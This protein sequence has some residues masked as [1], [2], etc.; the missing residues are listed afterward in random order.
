MAYINTVWITDIHCKD[1]A[2]RQDIAEILVLADLNIEGI[3]QVKGVSPSDI[4]V[5]GSGYLTSSALITY[6]RFYMYVELL[7]AYWG[8]AHGLNDIYYEKLQYFRDELAKAENG[9]TTDNI[10]GNDPLSQSSFI[11]QVPIY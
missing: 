4:P 10:L 7:S 11:Q 2:T 8:S 6:A 3:V 5:D 9:L 1:L